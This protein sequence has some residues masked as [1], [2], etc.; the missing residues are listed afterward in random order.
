M[1]LKDTNHDYSKCLMGNAYSND[2]NGHFD[3]WESFKENWGGF[4]YRKSDGVTSYDDT[5]NF[6]FRYDLNVDD[7]SNYLELCF[8]LQRKGI[9][10]N[11]IVD[12][13]TEK[14]MPEITE[15]LKGRK[16]YLKQLWSDV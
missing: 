1:E 6:L 3:S 2:A 7:D 10:V 11:V 16:E 5:Y 13:I 12:N 8:M 15:W 4:I 9:Y 14:D